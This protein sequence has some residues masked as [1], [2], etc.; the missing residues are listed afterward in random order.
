[1]VCSGDSPLGVDREVLRCKFVEQKQFNIFFIDVRVR[2][3]E[4]GMGRHSVGG[5]ERYVCPDMNTSR[6]FAEP[7]CR[8]SRKEQMRMRREGK[9][10]PK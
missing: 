6:A 10:K 2:S 5:N 7:S 9:R 4:L 3:R 8:P 1:M